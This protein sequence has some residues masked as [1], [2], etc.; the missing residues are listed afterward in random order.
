MLLHNLLQAIIGFKI[1]CVCKKWLPGHQTLMLH[2]TFQTKELGDDTAVVTWHFHHVH[3]QPGQL[4]LTPSLS[5][6]SMR[7]VFDRNLKL[8]THVQVEKLDQCG[9]KSPNH[10]VLNTPLL[11]FAMWQHVHI[12][13]VETMP[14]ALNLSRILLKNCSASLF[15][16]QIAFR[17]CLVWT[18]LMRK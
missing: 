16:L 14:P 15:S 18:D 10:Q 4:E 8:V 6:E 1:F 9:Q 7:K 5:A 12:N 2:L 11:I 17:T 3:L 13:L